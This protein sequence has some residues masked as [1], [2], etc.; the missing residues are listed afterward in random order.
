MAF[1]YVMA[2][3]ETG[4]APHVVIQYPIQRHGAKAAVAI[5]ERPSAP[6]CHV[7]ITE[8]DGFARP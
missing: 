6:V 2:V 8:N 5:S 7:T 3:T 4:D 1:N